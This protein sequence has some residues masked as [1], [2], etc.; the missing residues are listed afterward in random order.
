MK[1]KTII[2][3]LCALCFFAGAFAQVNWTAQYMGRGEYRHG[4]QNPA[5]TNSGFAAFVG[6]RARVGMTYSADKF[7]INFSAQD[8]RTWGQTANG[9]ADVDGLLS[10]QEANAELLLSEKISVKAGRQTI[11]YDEDRIFGSLDWALFARRHDAAVFKYEDSTFTSHAGFAYNQDRPQSNTTVYFLPNNY[12]TFQYV[13]FSKQIKRLNLSALLLN[14]GLQWTKSDTNNVITSSGV[15][16]SQ[17]AG[18]RGAYS[19][20][21]MSANGTFYFQGGKDA[22]GNTLAAYE[23]SAEIGYKPMEKLKVIAGY[24][25]LSGT[26]QTDTANT[27]NHAFSPLFGT[28]HRFN[29]YMDLF[30]VGN[31][32]NNVGLQDP[33]VKVIYTDKRFI[34]GLDAHF[35]MAAAPIRDFS[36]LAAISE[37]PGYLGAE[38]DLTLI[39][40][41]ADYVSIQG[42]YSHFLPTASFEQVR[43]GSASETQNWA[44]IMLLLRPGTKK[45]PKTGLK[46]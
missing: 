32:G 2:L 8:V 29:G 3:G 20:N 45:F 36:D 42:G 1:F 16:F 10:I 23:A 30:Y 13:Y 22:A 25:I 14:N 26:S 7:R 37:M 28:N 11:A 35:F 15:R 38:I 41:I 40:K 9:S 5:A 24:E 34:A 39:Y 12:K 27:A 33:Y 19:K 4:Y 18:L 17:T 6:Q 46:M 31:F 43:G 21:K 44:Y